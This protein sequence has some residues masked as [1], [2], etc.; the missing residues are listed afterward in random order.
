MQKLISVKAQTGAAIGAGAAIPVGKC[1]EIY[2]DVTLIYGAD[3]DCV[4]TWYEADNVAKD[5]PVLMTKSLQIWAAT[6]I[7][8]SNALIRQ[9]NA[10]NYTID[11]TAGKSQTVRF[12]IDPTQVSVGK[13]AIYPNIGN[14]DAANLIHAEFHVVSKYDAGVSLLTD[15]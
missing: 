2:C 1:W 15:L 8:T 12:K 9:T 13:T 3:A 11:T 4:I 14:S 7:D 6:D 5:N 10:A